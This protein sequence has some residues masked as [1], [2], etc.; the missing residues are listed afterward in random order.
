VNTQERVAALAGAARQFVTPDVLTSEDIGRVLHVTPNAARGML[1]SGILP[2]K[3][4]GRRWYTIKADLLR[5]LSV[6][7]SWHVVASGGPR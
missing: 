3:R 2:G 5:A 6:G 4:V 7:A 1:R